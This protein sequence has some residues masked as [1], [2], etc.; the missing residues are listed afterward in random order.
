MNVSI[1]YKSVKF[2][3]SMLLLTIATI[4]L[5]VGKADFNNWSTFINILFGTYFTANVLDKVVTKKE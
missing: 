1:K 2:Q 3:I 5:F 4:A